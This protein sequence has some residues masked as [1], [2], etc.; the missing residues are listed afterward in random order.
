MNLR[1]AFSA[2]LASAAACGG[3]TTDGVGGGA[4][5]ASSSALCAPLLDSGLTCEACIARE[6]CSGLV[7]CAHDLD[8]QAYVDCV[9]NCFTAPDA[10]TGE[11]CQPSCMAA[12]PKGAAACNGYYDCIAQQCYKNGC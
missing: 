11:S 9:T 2:A 1:V 12:H 8:G 4:P 7:T 10:G 3:A 6:C 5:D